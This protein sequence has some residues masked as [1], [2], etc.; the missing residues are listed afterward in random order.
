MSCSICKT[1]PPSKLP[2]W[3]LPLCFNLTHAQIRCS[4]QSKGGSVLSQYNWNPSIM[5]LWMMGCVC[6]PCDW[7]DSLMGTAVSSHGCLTILRENLEFTKRKR[8]EREREMVSLSNCQMWS[9]IIIVREKE[10]SHEIYHKIK[11][12]QIVHWN[13]SGH[14]STLHSYSFNVHTQTH[15]WQFCSQFVSTI[16]SHTH[17]RQGDIQAFRASY[18][19]YH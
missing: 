17:L 9:L 6:L 13:T 4:S 8:K 7:V 18:D 12:T 15:I 16:H 14:P 2:S 19:L 11:L 10:K 1:R 3:T 5:P